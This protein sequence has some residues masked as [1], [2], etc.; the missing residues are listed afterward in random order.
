M[1]DQL[2]DN[3]QKNLVAYV[4]WSNKVEVKYSLYEMECLN[5]VCYLHGS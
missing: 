3:G 1:H 4:S 2:D 5:V